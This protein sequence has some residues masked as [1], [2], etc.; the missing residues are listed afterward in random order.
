VVGVLTR[1][2]LLKTLAE[3][4][5]EA[6]VGDVMQRDFDT[7]DPRDML[8]G[9]LNRLQ[10]RQLLPVLSNG[11]LVGLLTKSNLGE[12]LMVEDALRKAGAR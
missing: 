9:V 1:A 12:L 6:R 4:G 2:D 10:Q 3:R 11:Q 7:A 8:D 5:V